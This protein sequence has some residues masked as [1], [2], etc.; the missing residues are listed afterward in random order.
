METCP[1]CNARK[2]SPFHQDKER[3]Y[4]HCGQCHLVFVPPEYYLAP[5]QE[6]AQYEHHENSPADMGYRRFLGRLFDPLQAR[7]PSGAAGLDFGCG[8]GPTLSVM[9]E[10]AGFPMTLY[11]PFFAPDDSTLTNE[12]YDFITASEVV[13]HLHHPKQT[14]EILWA[15]LKPGGLLGIMTKQVIDLPMFSQWHYKQD[16]THVCFFSKDTFA[17][18][19]HHW[20]AEY[21]IIG[22]DVV[23]FS[24][25]IR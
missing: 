25:P 17:W 12:T 18:L 24:K 1:L 20:Q 11:D 2:V 22:K 5:D 6:R 21:R 23:L 16:P 3:R 15:C 9:C 19:A 4:C 10:E 14:F 8:P 7:L 13:E